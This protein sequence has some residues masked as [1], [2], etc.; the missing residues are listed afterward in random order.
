MEFPALLDQAG[1]DDGPFGDH[2]KRILVS[3]SQLP[4][5]L[6]A[7]RSSLDNPHLRDAE[8]F[9]RLVSRE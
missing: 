8:G 2:L 7:L 6:Q 9:H 5:V 1:R 4:E 3:V